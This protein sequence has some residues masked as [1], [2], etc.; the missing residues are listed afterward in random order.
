[1]TDNT[2]KLRVLF[3]DD[4]AE[5]LNGLRLTLRK[6][7]KHFDFLFAECGAEALLTL[8][9]HPV[10]V[11]CTDLK[12][13]DTDGSEL[14]ARMVESY[15]GVGRVVLS[16]HADDKVALRALS[17][18]HRLLVKPTDRSSIVDAL[19][20]V[21]ATL[22][23]IERADLREAIVGATCLPPAPELHARLQAQLASEHADVKTVTETLCQD[24][25]M[26]AKVLQFANSG[27]ISAEPNIVSVADATEKLGLSTLHAIAPHV[28]CSKQPAAD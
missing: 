7:R 15:P 20:D 19:M 6:E 5:I 25:A 27:Y 22:E 16:G 4:E 8:K 11:V 26:A 2:P 21:R 10:D 9:N 1:M 3:V 17:L 24:P 23:P 18:A 12:M 28:G 14:L 13:P